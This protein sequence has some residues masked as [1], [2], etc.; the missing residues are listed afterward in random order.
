MNE[1]RRLGFEPPQR[2]QAVL[3]VSLESGGRE[4]GEEPRRG[5]RPLSFLAGMDQ[6]PRSDR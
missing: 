6:P 2:L 1:R 4:R 3:I 5:G